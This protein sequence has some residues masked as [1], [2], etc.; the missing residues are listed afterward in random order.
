MAPRRLTFTKALT[1]AAQPH[2]WERT[3]AVPKTK[4]CVEGAAGTRGADKI[5]VEVPFVKL[6]SRTIHVNDKVSLA[7]SDTIAVLK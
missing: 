6:P 5:S 7:Y 2:V 3:Y 4:K 1:S